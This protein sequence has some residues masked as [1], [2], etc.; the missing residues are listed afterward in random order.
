MSQLRSACL[1]VQNCCP[2]VPPLGSE[3]CASPS[4]EADI[5]G[6]IFSAFVCPVCGMGKELLAH[7]QAPAIVSQSAACAEHRGLP[8][9]APFHALPALSI[10]SPRP[11]VSLTAL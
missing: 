8:N 1:L 6:V 5:A 9:K 7:E 11:L 10:I 2:S 4:K 3:R